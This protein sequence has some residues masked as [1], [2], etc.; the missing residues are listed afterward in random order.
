VFVVGEEAVEEQD[1]ELQEGSGRTEGV[2]ESLSEEREETEEEYEPEGEL[3]LEE[4]TEAEVSLEPSSSPEP[5][6][7]KEDISRASSRKSASQEFE[8]LYA[9][10]KAERAREPERHAGRPKT[11]A[12]G[13]KTSIGKAIVWIA[14]GVAI[15]IVMIIICSLR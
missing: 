1:E 11:A 5:L 14:I 10:L 13:K 4:A 6:V 7:K 2:L 15:W 3:T 8:E 12:S 9:S